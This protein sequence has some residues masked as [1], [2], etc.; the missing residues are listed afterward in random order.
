MLALTISTAS[1][2]PAG[3]ESSSRGYFPPLTTEEV[4]EGD[5]LLPAAALEGEREERPALFSSEA[6]FLLLSSTVSRV[7]SC[8][9]LSV[10]CLGRMGTTMMVSSGSWAVS[11]VS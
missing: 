7:P 1:M 5:L 8:S 6:C 10:C 11:T 3:R 2:S 4:G 9:L